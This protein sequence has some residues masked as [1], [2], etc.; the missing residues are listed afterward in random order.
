M[1]KILIPALLALVLLLPASCSQMDEDARYGETI[2]K[3]EAQ[4]FVD[5]LMTA[6]REGTMDRLRCPRVQWEHIPALLEY[7]KSTEIVGDDP[8]SGT[9]RA[10]PA[11][12]ISSYL[13]AQC[14]EGMFALWMVEAARI[15]TLYNGNPPEREYCYG[16]PSQNP[17]VQK[18]NTGGMP[19]WYIND[20]QVQKELLE[21]YQA[22][23]SNAKGS[24][25]SASIN[26]LE[27]TGYRWH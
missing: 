3:A 20:T 27:D 5:S 8:A 22:W 13:M 4:H 9:F 15:N 6:F 24:R 17:F 26:P 1:K 16:W 21:A 19:D 14:S 23:W 7:G 25:S 12:P 11:N 18:Q 10:L 2:T